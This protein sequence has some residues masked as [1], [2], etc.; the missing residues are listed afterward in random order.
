M[1]LITFKQDVTL[2]TVESYDEET[3]TEETSIEFFK[4]G[5]VHDIDILN[6]DENGEVGEFVSIQF[7]D[8]SCCYGISKEFIEIKHEKGN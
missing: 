8:G 7:G 4:A 6:E 5:E 2:E 1:A 3:D